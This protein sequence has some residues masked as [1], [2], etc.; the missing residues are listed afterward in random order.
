MRERAKYSR[1]A[2]LER[3]GG[4][5]LTAEWISTKYNYKAHS[6]TLALKL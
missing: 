6:N 3:R 1:R 2:T 4:P 5:V